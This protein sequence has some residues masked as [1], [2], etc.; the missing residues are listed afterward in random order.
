L[1]IGQA[2]IA[3]SADEQRAFEQVKL[4]RAKHLGNAIAMTT[5]P[6]TLY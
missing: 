6:Q 5:R 1:L 3:P 2:P 4:A